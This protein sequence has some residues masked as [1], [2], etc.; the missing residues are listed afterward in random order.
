MA[1]YKF[2]RLLGDILK[3]GFGVIKNYCWTYDLFGELWGISY[4]FLGNL[5]EIGATLAPKKFL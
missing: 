5:W 4:R 2:E 3:K 1:V